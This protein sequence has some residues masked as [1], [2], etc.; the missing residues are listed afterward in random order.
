MAPRATKVMKTPSGAD[1]HKRQLKTQEPGSRNATYFPSFREPH[2]RGTEPKSRFQT[3]S[4]Q[5]EVKV[6]WPSATSG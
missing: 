1:S 3:L 2:F 5:A 4:H 6:S